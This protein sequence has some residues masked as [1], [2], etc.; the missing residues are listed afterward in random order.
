MNKKWKLKEN[1]NDRIADI[2]KKFNLTYIVSQK[3]AEKNLSDEEIKVFLNPTRKDFH[4]PFKLPDMEKAV[5][6]ILKAMENKEKI[7]IYGD[8][9]ADGIT[10]TTILKRF[11]RDRG[12]EVRNIY[13]K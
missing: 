10:S 3:L 4:N 2:S 1:N 9:D 5:D 7:V 13:S 8:Y 12:I 6:R 11:I